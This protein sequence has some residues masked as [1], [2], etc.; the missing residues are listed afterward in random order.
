MLSI[1]IIF[2]AAFFAIVFFLLGAV[3]KTL[4]AMFNGAM[5]TLAFVL[6]VAFLSIVAIIVLFMIYA[7]A[8]GDLNIGELI[9]MIISLMIML[10]IVGAILGGLGE[11]ILAVVFFIA[12]MILLI[13][14]FVLESAAG[15]CESAY[16][17]FLNIIVNRFEKC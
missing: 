8:H 10:G 12:Q 9:G 7:I 1:V 3:F 4:A 13:T 11:L 17:F 15:I 5:D 14:S 16:V 2:W 6:S